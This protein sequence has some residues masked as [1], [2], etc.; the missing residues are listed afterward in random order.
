MTRIAVR[1]FS[2]RNAEK[3]A[4]QGLH[5]VLA[6]LMAARGLSTISEL[7]NEFNALIAPGQLTHVQ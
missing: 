1:Q 4:Q 3:L 7:S 6:R 5:P 2:S